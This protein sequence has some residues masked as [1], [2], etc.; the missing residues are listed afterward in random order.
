[1]VQCDA[2]DKE[3]AGV[4]DLAALRKSDEERSLPLKNEE[5]KDKTK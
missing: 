2:S 4:I 5:L 1:M 3:I